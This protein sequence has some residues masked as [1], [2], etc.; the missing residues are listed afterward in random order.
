[1]LDIRDLNVRF[2]VQSG[3]VAAVRNVSLEVREKQILGIVG[4][5][6]CGKSTLLYSILGLNKG[7][8]VSG[9][10][11]FEGQN[12]VEFSRADWEQLRGNK[13]AM[14]FQD[15]MST[16][17]PIY[18]IGTQIRESLRAHGLSK[19]QGLFGRTM[20]ES[21]RIIELMEAVGI[22]SPQTRMHSYPH[23]FS[24][25]MQQRALIATALACK[26]RL[27]LADEP[28]TALD[29][30]IQAQIMRLLQQLNQDMGMTIII[31]T[32]DL[33]LAAEYCDS[34][35]VMYAGE[36]VEQG[37]VSEV[38]FSPHH[39]YTRGLIKSIPS[40]RAEDGNRL[41]TIPGSVPDLSESLQGCAFANRCGLVTDE[42][43]MERPTLRSMT[44]SHSSR[45]LLD[46]TRGGS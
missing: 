4:E 1:M 5:S 29:V 31:V 40:E 6:G 34:I 43:R 33:A 9:E 46:D 24:G 36:V 28:T 7:A 38:I 18:K 23:E 20:D 27:L 22:P 37:T 8:K 11:A 13:I 16:L 21:A 41:A 15:P 35:A 14:I 39:P 30:T 2:P 32:H 45:C 25:G 42:C 19:R 12:L 3:S 17:N 44:P 26:P 10:I